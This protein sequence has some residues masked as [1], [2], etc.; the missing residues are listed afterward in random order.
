MSFYS[1][2]QRLTDAWHAGDADAAAALFAVDAIYREPGREALRGRESIG[3]FM[4]NFFA[5]GS[6]VRVVVGDVILE[7]ETAFVAFTF[8][9]R[10]ADGEGTRTIEMGALVRF[11]DGYVTEWRE[12]R[13]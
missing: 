7:G 13:G 10:R 3:D 8:T 1:L 11:S 2:L 12:Y 6:A 5:A 4:R 9:F